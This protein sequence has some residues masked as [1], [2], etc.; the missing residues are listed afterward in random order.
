MNIPEEAKTKFSDRPTVKFV[1]GI[2]DIPYFHWQLPILIESLVDKLPYGWELLVVVCN[3]HQP[4]S[5]SLI[6]VFLAYDVNGKALPKRHG[7]P[8]R[9][10]AEDYYGDDW[11]K[12][13]YKMRLEKG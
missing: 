5:D 4:L 10:V 11:V 6:Q 2:E 12:Y 9:V 1:V 3:N 13:V 8:L 7:F